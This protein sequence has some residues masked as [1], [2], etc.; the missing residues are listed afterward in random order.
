MR[1]EIGIEIE[2]GARY[3]GVIRMNRHPHPFWTALVCAT[4]FVGTALTQV[5]APVAPVPVAARPIQTG[6]PRASGTVSLS[7]QNELNAA[8]DRGRAWLMAR[9]N[10]DG[11]WGV[12]NRTRLTAL[13]A[14]ALTRDASAAERAATLRAAAWL[15]SPDC[16][17][18]PARDSEA[19]AWREIA[20]QVTTPANPL[21]TTAFL[22]YAAATEHSNVLASLTC[23]LIRIAASAQTSAPPEAVAC[24]GHAAG[25][26][27]ILMA[28]ARDMPG[29]YFASG[30]G[31]AA[32]TLARLAAHWM[33]HGAP[34]DPSL[35]QA[36]PLWICARFINR[37]GGGTLAD[38]GGNVLDWRNDVAQTLVAAQKI[39]PR[40]PGAG[41]WCA[42]R[43]GAQPA[44]SPPPS[45]LAETAFA[46][47]AMDEL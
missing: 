27:G 6:G 32:A 14:A 46:I 38:A 3:T 35:G 47:L 11:S 23:M 30:A 25:E 44:A 17:Q 43:E 5:P 40:M 28:C 16:T 24:A 37:A 36:Q 15:E 10:A 31:G 45:A 22:Q 41:F 19:A 7:L 33:V 42:P 29:P 9:Q 18:A 26:T 2:I 20:L 21:R 39:D 1:F 13:C 12:S 4:A 34:D 8:I